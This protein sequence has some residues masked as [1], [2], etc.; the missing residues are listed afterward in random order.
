[1][2]FGLSIEREEEEGTYLVCGLYQPSRMR[3]KAV[4][5]IKPVKSQSMSNPTE[6]RA[7]ITRPTCGNIADVAELADPR[8][9][10]SIN[11]ARTNGAKAIYQID[12][13]LLA[14]LLIDE[15]LA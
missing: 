3:V 2:R 14:Q 13:A 11:A 12:R 8:V 9:R 4:V 5:T 7:R 10:T 15:N 6:P 1:M